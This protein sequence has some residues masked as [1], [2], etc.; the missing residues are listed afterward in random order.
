[1]CR[2]REDTCRQRSVNA[3]TP[4]VGALFK[5]AVSVS[6]QCVNVSVSL[7][8]TA[9]ERLRGERMCANSGRTYGDNAHEM[10]RQWKRRRQ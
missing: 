6:A 10:H 8:L 9:I 5:R 4:E 2:Q 1:M 3:Q 7:H